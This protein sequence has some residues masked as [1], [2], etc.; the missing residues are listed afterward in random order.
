MNN[1]LALSVSVSFVGTDGVT[2][3][4]SIPY[5]SNSC[6]LFFNAQ[7]LLLKLSTKERAFFDYLCE[8]MGMNNND[9]F[10]DNSLKLAFI[11]LVTDITGGDVQ[12]TENAVGKYVQKLSGIG[13]VLATGNRA[14]YTVNPKYVFKGSRTDRQKCIKYH[15]ESRIA[16]K[17]YIQPL[18]NVPEANFLK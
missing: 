11:K 5:V 14:R 6:A 17:L 9:V 13:L 15:I 7:H 16:S 2:R 12:L 10:I 18:I 4:K 1:K 3:R 8:V